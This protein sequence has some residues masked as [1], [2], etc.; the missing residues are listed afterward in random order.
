MPLHGLIA[1]VAVGLASGV[2]SG[3][4]GVSPGG[5]LVV[6]SVLLLG[7]E[8]HVAQG[9]SL[10][11]QIPPTG[12]AGIRRYREAGQRAPLIWLGLLAIGFLVGGVAGAE[13]A[14]Q[15]SA[16]ALE[17]IYVAYLVG[18]GAMLILRREGRG[19]DEARRPNP[20]APALLTV[21]G[22]AGFSSGFLGIGGGLATIVGLHAVL[23]VAQ[24][25][26]QFVSLVLSLIPTSLPAAWIY[27]QAGAATSWVTIVGVIAGL[28]MGADLGA[29]LAMRAS[30]SVL[31]ITLI[32]FV[33]AMAAYMSFKAATS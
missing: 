12:L 8:Q 23:G 18:L 30:K 14:S 10:I 24:L 11:A 26:A 25:Q 32:V 27:W 9:V 1:G 20:S 2:S 6:F 33:A 3:L 31:R 4:L 21:G 15:V 19:G 29:R 7:A 22:I 16:G 28:V 5:G 13:A 17:W